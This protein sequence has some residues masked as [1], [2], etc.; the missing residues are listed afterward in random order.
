[1]KITQKKIQKKVIV[2]A[3]PTLPFLSGFIDDTKYPIQ[4]S[5]NLAQDITKTWLS[6]YSDDAI[7]FRKRYNVATY[8]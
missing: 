2:R 3:S 6:L 1:V 7:D 8:Y 5:G 4:D